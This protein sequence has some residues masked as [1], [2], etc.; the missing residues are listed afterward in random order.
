MRV[1][2]DFRWASASATRLPNRPAHK[3]NLRTLYLSS[4][5]YAKRRSAF[6]RWID[7]II[8]DGKRYV[9]ASLRGRMSDHSAKDV[10]D[11]TTPRRWGAQLEPVINTSLPMRTARV[12]E[13]QTMSTLLSNGQ[14][15]TSRT[16]VTPSTPMHSKSVPVWSEFPALSPT[17]AASTQAITGFPELSPTATT[18]TTAS[19]T[20]WSNREKSFAQ[21]AKTWATEQEAERERIKKEKAEAQEK[22][23]N[24]RALHAK[25]AKRVKELQAYHSYVD[26]LHSSILT[27]VHL[28]SSRKQLEEYDD[29]DD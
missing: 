24:L 19:T 11:V 15:R 6:F 1:F 7:R 21:L 10:K 5:H 3:K 26:M 29:E 25:Q 20:A 2:R 14:P 23:A 17:G 13:P 4:R 16:S 28:H 22:E 8:M 9:P 18:S 12:L 27:S